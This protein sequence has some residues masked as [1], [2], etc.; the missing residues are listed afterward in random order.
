L[1]KLFET[2]EFDQIID[3]VAD[4]TVSILGRERV[5]ALSPTDA[6]NLSD[7]LTKTTEMRDLLDF[8]Q[9]P[10][11]DDVADLRPLLKK[12]RLIGSMLTAEECAH[13]LAFL[14]IIRR[15]RNY[16][17]TAE[18]N[19]PTLRMV[20]S[21]LTPLKTLEDQLLKCIDPSTFEVKDGASP[22]LASVR[23]NIDRAQTAARRK[24]EARMKTLAGE[25]YLQENLIAVRNGRMVLVVKD[26]FKR[27]VKGLV[28]D[29]SSTGSSFFIE[30]LEV[31]EDN[32]RVR[33]LY[34]EELKEIE[35]I[36]RALTDEVRT[37][38]AEIEQNLQLYGEIDFIH[39]KARFS[40]LIHG[41][42]PE[43]EYAPIVALRQARHPLLL[44]RLGYEHVVPLDVTLGEKNHTLIISGPNAGGKTVALK[45]IGLL[46][47][48]TLCG[49]HIPVSS[50]SRMGKITRIFALIGDQQ[51][52]E[53]DL[54][55]FSSHVQQLKSIVDS[56][57]ENSLVLIDEIGAG[58]DPE[59]GSSLAIAFLEHVTALSCL[60]VVTTHSS[61]LKAFAYR[62]PGVENSSLEFDV[63]TLKP[64]YKFRTG[65]P[66]SSY[67]FEIAQRI[68]LSP[69]VTGRARE[70]VGAQKNQLEGLILELDEK[71]QQHSRL[72][73]EADL[74]E[75]EY[76]GLLNLYQEKNK[77]LEQEVKAIKRR[78]AEEA[79]NLLLDSNAA[80]ER[81]IREI[82][83]GQAAK[84]VV[85]SVRQEM[86]TQLA[87]VE[88]VKTSS[89][90]P[91]E[92]TPLEHIENG[93]FVTWKKN[94]G[95]GVVISSPD[96]KGRVMVQFEGGVKI[97][98][99]AN[100]LRRSK[101]KS[102]ADRPVRVNLS[103]DKS[104][105]SEIDLRGQMS[106]EALDE[107]AKFLDEALMN[108]LHEVSIIHGK[109]TG[110]LRKAVAEF[111][112]SHPQVEEFRLGNWNEGTSGV[113]VAYFKGYKRETEKIGG[114]L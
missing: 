22:A 48:M 33:E 59:E 11:L 31:V 101:K 113:T 93:D 76:R 16:F 86:D 38:A 25:G 80:I 27:K 106:E 5:L 45:T 26:E 55:T 58:T 66:G 12:A 65:I 39:A 64:T 34:A 63:S 103:S 23:R 2:L 77:K 89:Q 90:E 73:R 99:P 10:P 30:P 83:E 74:R 19:L 71:V 75:T 29:Q 20:T 60:T 102:P 13:T 41:C 92:D 21:G 85:K 98:L 114:E 52:L 18:E 62:T 53:N 9:P 42:R 82:K 24:M 78:A 81:A 32:N 43:L 6:I 4:L 61:P 35:K 7:E 14:A 56:A 44:L 68:G 111:L 47:L 97:M 49:L 88:Q 70:L 95:A 108:G 28:H 112:R 104:F 36:L 84:E 1:K 54:S 79:E 91:E 15:L 110:A 87:K 67:A 50:L 105:R 100:E 46:A 51:S 107:V 94:G 40:Q 69:Q 96:K 72:A 37:H 57:D 109:G 3:R 17:S 8:H